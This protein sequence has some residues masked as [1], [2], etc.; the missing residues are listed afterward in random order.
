MQMASHIFKFGFFG[1]KEFGDKAM[2]ATDRIIEKRD[3]SVG[4]H[5]KKVYKSI[6]NNGTW[7]S[8][9]GVMLARVGLGHVKCQWMNFILFFTVGV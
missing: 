3:L 8:R 2:L 6:E 4:G 7:G 5:T 1:V 9:E